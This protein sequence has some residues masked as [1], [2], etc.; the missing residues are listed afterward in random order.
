MKKKDQMS[1]LVWLL[2]AIYIC[3]ESF[4]LPIGSWRDPGPGFLP[5]GAGLFLGILSIIVFLQASFAPAKEPG[6]SLF[7][8]KTW[9]KMIFCLVA[10]LGYALTLQVLGFLVTTYIFLFLLFRFGIETQS[11]VVSLAGSALASL[12]CYGIFEMWLKTQLP[13]GIIGF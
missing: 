10:L 3:F 9:R 8:R 11:W 6:E 13:K 12:L 1:S 7:P 4:R 5:L 2:A